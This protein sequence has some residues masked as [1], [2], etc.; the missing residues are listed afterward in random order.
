MEIKKIMIDKYNNWC[1]KLDNIRYKIIRSKVINRLKYNR[2]EF[3][4]LLLLGFSCLVYLLVY[5]YHTN[6]VNTTINFYID[7]IIWTFICILIGI[8]TFSIYEKVIIQLRINDCHD[9]WY[10]MLFI[11]R[12]CCYDYI[13]DQIIKNSSISDIFKILLIVV[14]ILIM[15]II[16]VKSIKEI[17]KIKSNKLSINAIIDDYKLPNKDEKLEKIYNVY[18]VELNNNCYNYCVVNLQKNIQLRLPIMGEFKPDKN[19]IIVLPIDFSR[20]YNFKGKLKSSN[21]NKYINFKYFIRIKREDGGKIKIYQHATKNMIPKV[22][23]TNIRNFGGENILVFLKSF[24]C[25]KNYYFSSDENREKLKSVFEKKHKSI[26]ISGSRGTGKTTY[27]NHYFDKNSTVYISA[28][29]E[30]A[31]GDPIS[32]IYTQIK[33]QISSFS[34]FMYKT[35]H[36]LLNIFRLKWNFFIVLASIGLWYFI[37]AITQEQSIQ[38]HLTDLLC[39]LNLNTLP[40]LFVNNAPL[41]YFFLWI[42]IYYL[43]SFFYYDVIVFIKNRT[44]Y[45]RDKLLSFIED[46]YRFNSNFIIVIEDIDRLGDE[47]IN[48]EKIYDWKSEIATLSDMLSKYSFCK[49]PGLIVSIS[50]YKDNKENYEKNVTKSVFNYD[51]INKYFDLYIE[52]NDNIAFTDEKIISPDI[53][54][55]KKTLQEKNPTIETISIEVLKDVREYK[56]KILINFVDGETDKGKL[57][58]DLQQ[59]QNFRE[60]NAFIEKNISY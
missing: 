15:F 23:N 26:L 6:I 13:N 29:N 36:I 50:K 55:Y 45:N 42:L 7:I 58:N 3:I 57:T 21:G 19:T 48:N 9:I 38:N 4:T 18:Y 54:N 51:E 53:R 56:E 49:N 2:S 27:I 1:F 39:K 35:F 8:F 25:L 46:I 33:K 40:E 16:T 30:R 20:T 41:I 17:F 59:C 52:Y 44:S 31:Y 34:R 22:L 60:I 11:I 5:L 28:N 37:F 24:N 47:G 43:L 12:L 10:C 14:F 32:I